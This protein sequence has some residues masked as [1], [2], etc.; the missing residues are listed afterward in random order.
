MVLGL[1]PEP[2]PHSHSIHV[3]PTQQATILNNQFESVFSKPK[4]LSLKFLAE[5][6]L[7]FQGSNPKNIKQMPDILITTTGTEKTLEKP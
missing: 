5:L 6:E 7:W 2:T 1:S 4:A 3:D